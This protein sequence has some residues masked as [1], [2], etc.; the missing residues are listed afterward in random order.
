MPDSYL[1]GLFNKSVLANLCLLGTVTCMPIVHEVL[2]GKMVLGDIT[3]KNRMT[4]G[5]E[6]FAHEEKRLW[7]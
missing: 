6:K 5:L 3:A 1:N 7:D 2:H 4:L